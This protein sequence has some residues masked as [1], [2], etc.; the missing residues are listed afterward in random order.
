MVH[1]SGMEHKCRQ[2]H[3]PHTTLVVVPKYHCTHGPFVRS[4]VLYIICT[5]HEK[6]CTVHVQY[7]LPKIEPAAGA[8]VFAPRARSVQGVLCA[9]WSS[10]KLFYISLSFR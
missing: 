10:E 4:T 1:A 9:L 7:E 6:F 5:V 2:S 8:M 3:E